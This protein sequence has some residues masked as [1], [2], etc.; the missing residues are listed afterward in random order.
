MRARESGR[1]STWLL[2]VAVLCVAALGGG[3]YAGRYILGEEYLK[4]HA[5]EVRK[6]QPLSVAPRAQVATTAAETRPTVTIAPVGRTRR[7]PKR[8]GTPTGETVETAPALAPEPAPPEQVT[9]QVGS[10]ADKANADL[11]ERDLKKHGVATSTQPGEQDGRS[12]YKVRA[13][14]YKSRQEA[15]AA[16]EQLRSRGYNAVIVPKG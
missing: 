3:Y 8:T 15:E 10:F 7:Q 9:I 12:V 1:A 13:G 5:S 14:T 11:L 2:V 4:K 16:A 6:P